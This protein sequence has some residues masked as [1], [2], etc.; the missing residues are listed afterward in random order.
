MMRYQEMSTGA[1]V[2]ADRWGGVGAL[3]V[4]EA[5]GT[6]AYAQLGDWLVGRRTG[7]VEVWTQK[8]FEVEFVPYHPPERPL[9]RK[10]KKKGGWQ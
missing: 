10:R 2:D 5:D 1:I 8:D 6:I 7:T 3:V 9:D 4:T